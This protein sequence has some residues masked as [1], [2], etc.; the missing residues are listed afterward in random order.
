MTYTVR[1]I[2][3]LPHRLRFTY[4]K[5][6]LVPGKADAAAQEEFLADYEK[7]KENSEEGDVVMFV[8]ATHPQ[9]NPVIG[10]GWIV[11][12]E[13]HP[14]RSNTGRRRLKINGAIDIATMSAQVRFDPTIDA[15]S[16]VALLEQIPKA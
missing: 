7:L 11:R 6:K 14:I 5:A 15:E 13:E 1:G 16:T 4:K 3:G 2:T 12:G 9:H 10:C 8:D